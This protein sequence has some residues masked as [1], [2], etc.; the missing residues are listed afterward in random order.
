M[1]KVENLLKQRWTDLL[2]NYKVLEDNNCP[3]IYILAYT[4]KN[5]EG[6]QIKIKDIFYVGMTNSRGGLKQRLKQFIDGIHK[7]YGHSAGN[8]FF[9]DY[10][11][12]KSFGI[13]RH[14]KTFFVALLSL[15]CRVYKNDRTP[16]DLR[17]MGEVAKFEYEVMA[18]IKEK[19]GKEPELNK[20]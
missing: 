11:G 3:G 9:S 1:L 2:K 17:K 14:K 6:K 13:A 10:S 18:Y 4:D 20:K 15:P 7:G 12:G 8:R 5:L 19:L 16:E